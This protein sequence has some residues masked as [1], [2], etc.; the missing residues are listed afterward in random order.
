MFNVSWNDGGVLDCDGVMHVWLDNCRQVSSWLS[1]GSICFVPERNEVLQSPNPREREREYRPCVN[2][3][4]ENSVSC[5]SNSLAQMFDFRKCIRVHLMLIL[6]LQ[7]LLQNQNLETNL[8]CIVVLCFQQ[9]N[10]A[11]IHLYH[12]CKRSNGPSVCRKLL[13]IL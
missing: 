11:G 13:S 7:G 9:N 8:V 6:N 2:L 5:S 10:F 12:E 1:L 4:R 3:H